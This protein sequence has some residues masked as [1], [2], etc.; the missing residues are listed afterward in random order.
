M[1]PKLMELC[2]NTGST[3]FTI[4]S[5]PVQHRFNTGSTPVHCR[6][7]NRRDRSQLWLGPAAYINHGR[8]NTSGVYAQQQFCVQRTPRSQITMRHLSCTIKQGCT[9][10]MTTASTAR[11]PY[12]QLYTQAAP[13][14]VFL[15]TCL[16]NPLPLNSTPLHT[17]WVVP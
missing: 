14:Y 3:P 10:S 1:V 15:S 17:L 11:A 12:L 6:F 5:T 2:V 8:C 4:F 7:S 9:D 13:V 16:F